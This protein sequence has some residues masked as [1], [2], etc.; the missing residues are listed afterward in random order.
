MIFAFDAGERASNLFRIDRVEGIE[1]AVRD[2]LPEDATQAQIDAAMISVILGELHAPKTLQT[3]RRRLVQL[4]PLISPLAEREPEQ[5]DAILL[6]YAEI[7]TT[8]G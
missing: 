3:V 6:E 2:A 4:W 1:N 7:A 8:L 5:M